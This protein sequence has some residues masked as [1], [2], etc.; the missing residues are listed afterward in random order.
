[1]QNPTP[2]AAPLPTPVPS[3]APPPFPP[4]PFEFQPGHPTRPVTREEIQVIRNQ[5]GEMSNQLSSAQDRRERLLNEIRTAPSGTEQGLLQQ[6]QVLNDRIVR[7]ERDIEISGQTLRSGQVPVG[8]TIVPPPFTSPSDVA[9]RG[10]AIGVMVVVIVSIVYAFRRLARRGRRGTQA[11]SA[12]RDER[13]ERLE[14]AVDA[15]AI[16][17]ERVGEAQR[18]QTKLL[19]EANIMPAMNMGQRAAEPVR[20]PG[21]D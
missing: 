13:M 4:S 20:V 19:A 12:E 7:I 10:A 6:L 2:Q 5:R 16:E 15:I 8:I 17:V 3:T 18:F 21:A 9:E 14:Q 11:Y 1:M